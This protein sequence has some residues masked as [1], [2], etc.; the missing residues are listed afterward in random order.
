M[1]RKLSTTLSAALLV[2]SAAFAQDLGTVEFPTSSE[3]AKAQELFERGVLLLHSF[4]FEA[5]EKTFLDARAADAD[6]YMTYWGEA[7]SHNHPLL[8]ERDPDLPRG[9]LKK[10]APTREERLA[11]APTARERGF[12]EAVEELFG[13]GSEEERSVAYTDAMA[14]L[15]ATYPDDDEVQAFYSVSL[16]GRV[17][18]GHDKDYRLRMK[19][20]S[21]AENIYRDHPDHPGAAHYV[22]HS[23]DDPVHAPLA[24]TAAYRYAEI[25]PDAAHALHMPSH[26]FIQHGMWDRV[27]KSNDASYDSAIRLWQKRDG[28]TDTQKFYNDVYVWHALDWG[29]YGQLQTGDYESAKQSIENL[30]PVAAISKAGMASSGIGTMTARL[31]VES[32]QWEILP[33][34]GS[35]T[36]DEVF[37]SGMSAVKL[38]N[39]TAAKAAA[40]KL[41]TMYEAARDESGESRTRPTQIMT[42]ELKALIELAN[43]NGEQAASLMKSATEIAESMSA[44]N[45][46]ATPVKPAFE[47]YGEVLLGLGKPAEAKKAFE[48]SLLRM[49]NRTLSLRGLARA[50][51]E[52]GDA[53]TA[54]SSYRKVLEILSSYPDNAS[55]Q[56]AK[57][58]VSDGE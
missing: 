35:P 58:F 50:A 55:Y 43:G 3:S 21:I 46:T 44:P 51:G 42:L 49:P 2:A 5:A 12:M 1:I 4:T 48:T 30:K 47:L 20:G 34:D 6:F 7:L 40:A 45:G 28:L 33:L 57:G 23:F 38:D 32:E 31:I 27:V 26:I 9:V 14:R 24:L 15:A 17:R 8:A 25:A 54:Q 36:P 22:I 19:A 16:L 53:A 56:E 29:Q 11:M 52:T 41:D 37:A 13:E 39:M 10:L 18:F